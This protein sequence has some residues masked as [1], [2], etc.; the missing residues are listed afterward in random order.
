MVEAASGFCDVISFNCYDDTLE[1]SKWSFLYSFTE[2]AM[3]GEFHFPAADQGM[4]PRGKTR[5]NQKEK[6][7]A[8]DAYVKSALSTKTFIGA[9]WF[10]YVDQPLTGR[11]FD[12][13]NYEIGFIGV[14][15]L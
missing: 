1:P 9:H 13:E 8:R 5:L 3:I 4:F 12:S 14:T 11:W 2:P 15:D 6:L 7:N 10:Q